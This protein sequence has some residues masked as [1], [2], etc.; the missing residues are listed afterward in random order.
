MMCD[1]IWQERNWILRCY[2]RRALENLGK[3]SHDDGAGSYMTAILH[4]RQ[5]NKQG[6]E[7]GYLGRQ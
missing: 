2:G 3:Q 7:Y 6:T 4:Q 5:N 1:A